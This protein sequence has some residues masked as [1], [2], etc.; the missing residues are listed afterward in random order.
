MTRKTYEAKNA[1]VSGPYSHAVDAGDYVYFSGQTAKNTPT[2]TDM[3]GDIQAQTHQCFANL[4]DV[5]EASG[6]TRD[7]VVKVNVYLTSMKHF[8]AMN[9]VYKTQFSEP[10]P[11]RTC[12]AVLELPLEAEVEIEMIAK[13]S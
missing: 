11:A 13:R 4:F 9:E 2:A 7:D 12:V 10:Y 3:S 8:A 1:T 6:L 5:L